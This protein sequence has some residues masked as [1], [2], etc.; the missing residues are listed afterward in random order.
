MW[1]QLVSRMGGSDLSMAG[2][3]DPPARKRSSTSCAVWR[4]PMFR[5]YSMTE[6]GPRREAIACTRGKPL[7]V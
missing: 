6:F 2:W 5:L 7:A 3:H 4:S 1:R